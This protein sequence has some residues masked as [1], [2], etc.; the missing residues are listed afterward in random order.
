MDG[1]TLLPQESPQKIVVGL[2][3]GIDSFVTALLLKRM[4]YEVIGVNLLLNEKAGPSKSF[5]NLCEGLGIEFYVINAMGEFKE[6]IID[7]FVYDYLHGKTPSP[8]VNCNFSIK[9]ELLCR[10]ADELG[11]EKVATGHYVRVVSINGKYYI[12]KAKDVNKDQS[13]YLWGLKQSVLSRIITPLGDYTKEEVRRI[14]ISEHY[15]ELIRKKE[16]MSIC[17]LNNM[18]Y[19][20]FIQSSDVYRRF[21]EQG[22]F[23][24]EA[25]VVDTEGNILA[26]HDG[27]WNYTVGQRRNLPEL[28][29]QT[30][31][32]LYVSEINFEKNTL[33]LAPKCALFKK[34]IYINRCNFVSMEDLDRDDIYI[35]V[36]G[37]GMNPEGL[38][39]A[40]F[41]KDTGVLHLKLSE[42]AWALANGQPVV[43]YVDDRVIGGGFLFLSQ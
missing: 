20:R 41:C 10:T 18:D 5:V 21:I 23:E 31:E 33:V 13:Y 7:T 39:K 15:E 24:K 36:R 4:N 25:L 35:K 42:P 40:E 22:I 8:C 14:A 6:K 3:G 16:S 1:M 2:S 32:I 27:L 43:L 29:T 30:S 19:R 9:W 28:N 12:S 38:V 11:I 37:I 17:F 34:D 26:Y